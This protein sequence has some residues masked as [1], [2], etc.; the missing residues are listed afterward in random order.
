[1]WTHFLVYIV[2]IDHYSLLDPLVYHF[3]ALG[4]CV[5]RA[6]SVSFFLL[7]FVFTVVD[8]VC[9]NFLISLN[10]MSVF[11]AFV[12][13]GVLRMFYC[14]HSE[15]NYFIMSTILLSRIFCPYGWYSVNTSVSVVSISVLIGFK[16]KIT[17]IY[18]SAS[19]LCRKK[20]KLFFGHSS[21]LWTTIYVS[22]D[23]ASLIASIYVN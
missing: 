6:V 9:D 1:M 10:F 8:M 18:L 4:V 21:P 14:G 19:V 2:I 22:Y 20:F 17:F 5:R 15:K 3:I 7:S 23:V 11:V 12:F 13:Y 16:K